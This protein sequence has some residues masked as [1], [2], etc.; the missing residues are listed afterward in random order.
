MCDPGVT[1]RAAQPS[2]RTGL[3]AAR[4]AL[5]PSSTREEHDAELAAMLAGEPSSTLPQAI[6]VAEAAG[7]LVGFVEIG[8]RS[9]A[10]GCDP[11]RPVAFVEG[12]YVAP[13]MRRRGIGG[14][15]IAA[16]EDWGRSRGCTEIASDTWIDH[17][18]SQRAHEALGFAVVDRCVHYR[19][20]LF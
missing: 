4:S 17:T 19:K 9:H 1:I 2:D 7:A 13:E 20:A 6:L 8:L 5:W 11:R 16:A 10:D 12:W 18:I 15:L 3:A 14:A